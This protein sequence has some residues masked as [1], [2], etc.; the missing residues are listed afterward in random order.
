MALPPLI[1]LSYCLTV[2]RETVSIVSAYQAARPD[3]NNCLD[4]AVTA[5]S[6][7]SAS[8]YASQAAVAA[9]SLACTLRVWII[10][11]CLLLT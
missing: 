8:L 10:T 3:R 5:S 9:A 6:V 2:S 7:T 1:G 11:F 4:Y